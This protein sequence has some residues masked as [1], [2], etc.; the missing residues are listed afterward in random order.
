MA[1]LLYEDLTGEIIGAYY[2][3]YNGLSRTFPEFIYERAMMQELGRRG[4]DCTQQ[5]K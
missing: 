1:K 3:V 2:E 4:V 5:A